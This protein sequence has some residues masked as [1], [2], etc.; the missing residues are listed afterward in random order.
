M[1]KILV[2]D[3]DEVLASLYSEELGEEGYLVTYC[4]DPAKLMSE[5][6]SQ[7]PDLILI[8]TQMV[9]HPG[10]WFYREIANHAPTV[11]VI[12][13]TAG[14]RPKPKEWPIPPEMFVRKT[15]NLKA[16]KK[17]IRSALHGQPIKK[18]S[19]QVSGARVPRE[20]MGFL[21]KGVNH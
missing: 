18:R 21:W 10:E 19:A 13:Y 6:V 8:D 20:Q 16:L 12:L 1:K 4:N 7:K 11:P 15:Q 2:A 9:L 17:K 3:P 5:I 14:L